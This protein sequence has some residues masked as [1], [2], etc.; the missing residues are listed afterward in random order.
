VQEWGLPRHE[1]LTRERF[2]HTELNDRAWPPNG[3][4][5]NKIAVDILRRALPLLTDSY[6]HDDLLSI[7]YC[8]GYVEEREKRRWVVSLRDTL[9]LQGGSYE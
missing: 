6:A 9:S 3:T 1:R 4:R 7:L 2:D 5:G 8:R